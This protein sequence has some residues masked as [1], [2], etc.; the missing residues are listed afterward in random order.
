MYNLF[1]DSVHLYFVMIS[2]IY[3]LKF[4]AAFNANCK[5]DDYY[6]FDGLS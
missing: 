4:N 5:K 3:E 1:H 2:I 6:S